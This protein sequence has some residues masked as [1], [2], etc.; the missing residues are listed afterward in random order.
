M[1][2]W[3]LGDDWN[4]STVS[5]LRALY[6]W[7]VVAAAAGT[8]AA[9][10]SAVTWPPQREFALL[11]AAAAVASALRAPMPAG[12]YRSLR[13]AVA[14][15]GLGLFGAV[16]AAAALAA[17]AVLGDG[18]LRQRPL[19]VMLFNAAQGTLATLAAGS[20]AAL[21]HP[22]F[23]GWSGPL[24][25]ARES[26]VHALAVLAAAAAFTIVSS[27]L[28]SWHITLRRRRAFVGGLVATVG[29]ETVNMFLLFGFGSIA[30]L[31]INGSLPLLALLIA[32]PV[33]LVSV[34]L[35]VSTGGRHASAELEALHAAA[36]EI[37]LSETP[38][39]TT[40]AV[41]AAMERLVLSD[42]AMIWLLAPGESRAVQAYAVG[43]E[44]G[45]AVG[46]RELA[47]LVAEVVRS[48]RPVRSGDYARDRRRNPRLRPLADTRATLSALVVPMTAA[49]E[50][51]GALAFAEG[52]R[53]H[54]TARHEYLAATLAGHAAGA[55]RNAHQL[56]EGRRQAERLVGLQHLGFAPSATLDSDEAC[57]FLVRRSAE[58]LG[59]RYA[60]LVL[61]DGQ[62]HE[63]F[64]QA[65]YGTDEDAIRQ[66]RV[67]LD[68][69]PGA[70][71]EAVRA[72]RERRSLACTI[73]DHDQAHACR[74]P[75]LQALP[76]GRHVLTAPMIYQGRPV[77]ALTVVRTEPH[78]FSA[79]ETAIVEATAV[80]GAAAIDN[81]RACAALKARNGRLQVAVE[82][83]GRMGRAADLQAVFAL[84]SD[85]ARD[86][87]DTGRCMLLRWDGQGPVREA[88]GAG[89]SDELQRAVVERIQ[90]GRSRFAAPAAR[91]QEIAGLPAPQEGGSSQS[92]LLF[93]LRTN[94][95]LLGILALIYEGEGF[96]AEMEMAAGF[97][98]QVAAALER[99]SLRVQGDRRLNEL[100]LLNRIVG[101]VN[102]SL[103]PVEVC[104]I[105]V[106]ELADAVG[107]A[108]ATIHRPEGLMLRLVAQ[109]GSPDAHAEIPV[110]SGIRGRVARSGRP[111]FVS[112][113]RD[114][115]DHV[116]GSP[117]TVSLAAVPVVLEGV[118]TGV[119]TV[120]GTSARPLTQHTYEFLAEFASQLSI[121][122][123][124]ASLF[125][126]LRRTHDEL[127]VLFE[128]AKAVSGTLDLRTV[129][130][131]LVAVT[132]RAFHYENGALLMVDAA[133][134]LVTEAAY[135]YRNSVVGTRVA[136]GTG[137]SGWVARTGTP[138]VVDDV[139][140]DSRYNLVDDRVRSEMAVPLIAEG[141]V[142][143]VF[144]VES[145]R[146]AAF[147]SRDL[148]LLGTLASYAVV[149][150]QNARLYEQAQRLAITD[151][152]T[153]L[154]NHRYFYEALERLL[155]RARRDAQPLALI[156]A[157]IDRFKHHNDTFGHKSGDEVL[158]TIA[159]LLRRGSRPSDVV[160]RY[161]GDEFMVVLPGAS[162]AAAY[163]T[164]E[165]LR[166]TV[167]A[168]PLLA[169]GDI[170]TNVTMSVG[171]VAF[172]K[173][174][175]TAGALVE[176]ADRAQY[177]AKRAG[178][179]RVHA[180]HED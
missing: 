113:V 106:S 166:R 173:D 110:S 82:L 38:E 167:E 129:L 20:V 85:G 145:T 144:N 86:L 98:D 143:G 150:I 162:G 138:L 140:R 157:E 28:V 51:W 139:S 169:N 126:D 25:P 178:G 104:R 9:A 83:V 8:M 122:V 34:V 151:G 135:G 80:Q 79:T 155:E 76:E 154:Y 17:G 49:G 109:V 84:V 107:V 89:L 97:A 53:H 55:M 88:L 68:A 59:A 125:E 114:D 45:A 24:F 156:M 132:C 43:S 1:A 99:I 11:C 32:V 120:E 175:R 72:V 119:L 21:V 78:P 96:S 58:A 94:A 153:E 12:G 16:P 35:M 50:V 66:L 30:G 60:L 112:N 81:A 63:L 163:E 105:A 40:R 117:D 4:L 161:G 148:H 7:V 176:A 6:P 137:I 61:Y 56:E 174:G 130:D 44:N 136:A 118:T 69:E 3:I 71:H 18:L 46:H 26:V 147:G 33:V 13:P 67:G 15:A 131:S 158:R 123:R 152:L 108:R 87:F 115:P 93:P 164:A 74:C 27:V 91:P 121:A 52:D 31:V 124:N 5:R 22:G 54:F 57:R 19:R 29:A 128:A 39:E 102:A 149:A 2:R 170:I 92:A 171:V 70:L 133:G 36:L 73:G 103:D 47:G 77:G 10:L 179:N 146:L 101:S 42:T 75:L 142:L 165:R 90:D 65:A 172:P 134:D 64:G 116:P 111:E 23:A 95:R 141:K 41:A 127:Q 177:L 37:G 180:S 14:A 168:Y 160:A 62:R 159:G 100:V 48:G